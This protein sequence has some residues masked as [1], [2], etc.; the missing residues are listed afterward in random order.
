MTQSTIS[1]LDKS[2]IIIYKQY[3]TNNN[4]SE[5]IKQSLMHT[6]IMLIIHLSKI[7]CLYRDT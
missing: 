7:K 6:R 3:K 1:K 5:W 4:G 2:Y